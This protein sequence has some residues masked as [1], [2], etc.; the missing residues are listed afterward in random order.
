MPCIHQSNSACPFA[1]TEESEQVQNF[2]CLPTPHEI[3]IMRVDHGKTWA[4]HEQ[5]D[6]PC[7]GAI[8]WLKDHDLPHKVVDPVLLTEKSDWHLYAMPK[9]TSS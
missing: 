4:C 3:K 5:P 9:H 2:G 1:F 8:Q 6:R 7:K